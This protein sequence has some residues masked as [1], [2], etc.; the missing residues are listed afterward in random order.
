MRE[1]ISAADKTTNSGP[2]IRAIRWYVATAD[3]RPSGEGLPGPS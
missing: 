1:A 2:S 3:R